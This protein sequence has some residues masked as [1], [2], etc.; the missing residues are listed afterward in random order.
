MNNTQGNES[1]FIN[2]TRSVDLPLIDAAKSAI[3]N[4]SNISN[5][6]Q[7][8]VLS[9]QESAN[10]QRSK[11]TP[12]REPVSIIKFKTK[13]TLSP[14]SDQGTNPDKGINTAGATVSDNSNK[15][16][17]SKDVR[18]KSASSQKSKLTASSQAAKVKET[19]AKLKANR[20]R[21]AENM[22]KKADQSRAKAAQKKP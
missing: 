20:D 4:S 11:D 8:S 9:D 22:K 1:G 21:I 15:A 5:E 19:R 17:S 2:A 13:A 14:K 3:A 18:T 6:G 10:S 16:Q 12:V 7:N